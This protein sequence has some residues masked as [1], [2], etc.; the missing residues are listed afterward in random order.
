L[1]ETVLLPP[2]ASESQHNGKDVWF[3]ISLSLPLE[4]DA[5]SA[6]SNEWEILRTERNKLVHL[7]LATVDFNSCDQ[8]RKLD[9]ELD[10]QNVLFLKGIAFLR[11][12]V[13]VTHMGLSA[14]ASVEF[15]S[16]P[17]LPGAQ[18]K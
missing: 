12:M 17:L 8:C 5:R 11:K 15:A 4:A 14:M 18:S 9:L 10:A 13:S 3:A 6:W 16:D 7:M 2:D 1:A